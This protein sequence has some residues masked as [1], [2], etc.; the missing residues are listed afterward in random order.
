MHLRSPYWEWLMVDVGNIIAVALLAG[1]LL[2][3]FATFVP[4]AAG[5]LVALRIFVWV[6]RR[7]EWKDAS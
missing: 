2:G 4:I 5:P 6:R 1:V 3:T 7:R